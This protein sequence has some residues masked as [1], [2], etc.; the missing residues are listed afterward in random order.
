MKHPEWIPPQTVQ[1]Y[2][3][4]VLETVEYKY[5]WNSEFDEPRAE[6]IFADKIRD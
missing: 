2:A 5:P 4:L 6:D 3:N 1:W